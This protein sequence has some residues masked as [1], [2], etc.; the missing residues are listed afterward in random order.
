ME[1]PKDL[2]KV[3]EARN[4]LH[5]LDLISMI[6]ETPKEGKMKMM[7]TLK[8]HFLVVDACFQ[9]DLY[10]CRPQLLLSAI[11]SDGIHVM[12]TLIVC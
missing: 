3:I 4:P 8:I 11:A 9:S 5:K 2:R 12:K 10:V 1:G 6:H 7:C